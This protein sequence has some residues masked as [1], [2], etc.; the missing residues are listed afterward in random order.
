ME[1]EDRSSN[2]FPLQIGRLIARDF[3]DQFNSH[4]Q[5][6][7][8]SDIPQAEWGYGHVAGQFF[9]VGMASGRC[10]PAGTSK[11]PRVDTLGSPQEIADSAAHITKIDTVGWAAPIF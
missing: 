6:T 3:V 5:S 2:S 11:N 1:Q 4:I 7:T 8:I 9:K 10:Q